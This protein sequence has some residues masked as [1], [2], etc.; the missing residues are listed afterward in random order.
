MKQVAI[1]LAALIAATG[2]A[3][4]HATLEIKQ[5]QAG[6]S[7]K[8][9]VS[10]THGCKASPTIQVSVDI[11]EGLIGVKPMPKPGWTIT[12]QTGSYAR[13]YASWHGNAREGVK[14][15]VWSGGRLPDDF[16]DEFQFRGLVAKDIASGPL[17]VPVIQTCEAGMNNWVQI[18]EAK[19]E[20]LS[21]NALNEPAPSF[22]VLAAND[23][24][25]DKSVMAGPLKID[26]AWTRAT[27]NGAKVAG[28]YLRITNTGAVPDR[29]VSGTS[30]ISDKFEVHEMSMDGGV[31]K[32]RPL[33]EGLT[34]APGATVELKP[35][36]YHIMFTDLKQPVAEGST[37]KAVLMFE[38]AGRAE[39]EFKASPI[40]APAPAGMSGAAAG[41]PAGMH[42]MHKH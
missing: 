40:G 38:K 3:S 28:G 26:G 4:A 11:P 42:D 16:T 29:L 23:A 12:T 33:N 21:A 41:M 34:I 15:I 18:P 10:I 14:R 30:N 17:Y 31:M 27:P 39:V 37:I 9:I 19:S 5:V 36:G 22:M 32:M 35:G 1:S 6:T 20:G 13:D 2:I 25:A 7:Y 8:G 24:S